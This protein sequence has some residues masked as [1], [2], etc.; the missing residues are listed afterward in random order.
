M[1][2]SEKSITMLME[3][4]D[5][6]EMSARMF[7]VL[8]GLQKT[9]LDII[10]SQTMFLIATEDGVKKLS[11]DIDVYGKSEVPSIKRNTNKKVTSRGTKDI[12]N[13]INTINKDVED[14]EVTVIKDNTIDETS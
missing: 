10:K 7:E 12:I 4:I 1:D 3:T 2:T 9:L 6:G 11:R 5:D 14:G 8:G 13:A